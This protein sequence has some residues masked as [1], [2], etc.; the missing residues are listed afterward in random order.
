[1]A[2]KK[3][4]KRVV[5]WAVHYGGNE[6]DFLSF[7]DASSARN[8]AK[9]GDSSDDDSRKVRVV[10]LREVST[11]E[12]AVLRAARAYV[13]AERKAEVHDKWKPLLRAV[14]RMEKDDE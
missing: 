8:A 5:A 2:K 10:R 7:Y 6:D 1:M 11:A 9:R 13:R 3:K 12:E 14:E 4:T